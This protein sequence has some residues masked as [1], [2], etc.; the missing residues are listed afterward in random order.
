LIYPQSL[1]AFGRRQPT[2]GQ[3]GSCPTQATGLPATFKRLCFCR[4]SAKLHDHSTPAV[5]I[6]FLYIQLC[7]EVQDESQ[8]PDG[9]VLRTHSI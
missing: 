9:V 1:Q 2:F 7:A 5:I 8:R 3:T 4:G 6:V